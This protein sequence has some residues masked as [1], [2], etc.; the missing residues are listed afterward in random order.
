MRT[1]KELELPLIVASTLVLATSAVWLRATRD[2]KVPE[3][4]TTSL[5][6]VRL[7]SDSR[8]RAYV[9]ARAEDCRSNM[10]FL[11]M[12]QRPAIVAG[13]HFEAVLLIANDQQLPALSDSLRRFGYEGSVRTITADRGRI[14]RALGYATTPV[15]LLVGDGGELRYAAPVPVTADEIVELREELSRLSTGRRGS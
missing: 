5:F 3:L 1:W 14:V 8:Y 2:R 10:A 4:S 7:Q 9:V 13:I 15:V 11:T 12:F 6:G